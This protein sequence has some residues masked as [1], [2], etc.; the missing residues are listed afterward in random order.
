MSF[1]HSQDNLAFKVPA[2]SGEPRP[3]KYCK[4]KAA[5]CGKKH[6]VVSV[7]EILDKTGKTV[8][9]AAAPVDD[10]KPDVPDVKDDVPPEPSVPSVPAKVSKKHVS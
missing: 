1:H 8:E 10:V 7:C 6:V 9:P 5:K 2:A 3:S 4:A